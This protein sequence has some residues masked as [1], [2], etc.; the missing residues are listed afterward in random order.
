MALS[1]CRRCGRLVAA[2]ARICPNCGLRHPAPSTFTRVAW[3]LGLL[4]F[5]GFLLFLLF[6]G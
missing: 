5:L 4:V 1:P 3:L 2:D 6:R